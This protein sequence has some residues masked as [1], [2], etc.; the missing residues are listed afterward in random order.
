MKNDNQW[1]KTFIQ[2]DNNKKIFIKEFKPFSY[3][4]RNELAWIKNGLLKKCIN[5][6]IPDVYE[7]NLSGGYISMQYLDSIS[8]S[9][10]IKIDD[11][12]VIASEIHALIKR[13]NPIIK[14]KLLSKRDYVI[15]LMDYFETRFNNVVKNGIDISIKTK[16]WISSEVKK[17]IP[18]FFTIVHRDFYRRNII[19]T[20]DNVYLVDW[21]F[22]NISDPAQDIAKIIYEHCVK[23]RNE[24][25][26][27]MIYKIIQFYHNN[28]KIDEEFNNAKRRIYSFIPIILV[29]DISASFSKCNYLDINVNLVKDCMDKLYEQRA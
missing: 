21:E 11:L 2:N 20:K 1:H 10:L 8:N 17:N 22:A 14:H 27:R 6:K 12:V 18:K 5:F 19:K 4:L 13:K 3:E 16:E 25:D 23:N 24:I 29:E 26:V 15:Y 9:S 7:A 28:F